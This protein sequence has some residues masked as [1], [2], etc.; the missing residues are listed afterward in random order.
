MTSHLPHALA[1]LLMRAV[2]RAGEDALGYAGASLREMTRVA[3]A[4][5][6]I[7]ADIFVDNGDLIAA[8]LGELSAELD[9]VERAI[10]NGER[11]AIEAW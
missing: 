6:G 1:N 5:A 7:W 10:R 4:N 2:V 3:G 8:A 11:D 9:D